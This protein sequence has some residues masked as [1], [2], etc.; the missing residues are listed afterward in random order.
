[1]DERLSGNWSYL[2]PAFYHGQ[3]PL[4]SFSTVESGSYHV[5]TM[6]SIDKNV[7][8]CY[9]VCLVGDSQASGD[10]LTQYTFL[11]P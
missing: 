10:G 7:V 11:N 8:T 2:Y 6:K 4:F 5:Q 9:Y 1:M 3:Y